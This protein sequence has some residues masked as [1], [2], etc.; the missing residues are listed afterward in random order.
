MSMG[1]DIRTG[2]PVDRKNPERDMAMARDAARAGKIKEALAS[3]SAEIV[4]DMVFKCLCDRVG[5]V[6]R[7]DPEAR[8]AMRILRE[9]KR[10]E[11]SA[12][13]VVKRIAGFDSRGLGAR[14]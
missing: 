3:E 11:I 7:E 14:K 2:R 1:V 5:E 10:R 6:L 8:M 12:D 4:F 9:M 13:T